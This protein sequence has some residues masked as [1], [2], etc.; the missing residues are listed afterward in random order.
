MKISKALKE[1]WEWKEAVYEETKNMDK[2]EVVKYFHKSVGRLLDKMD[3][4]KIEVS[5][6]VYRLSKK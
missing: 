4:K 2:K 1:V 5:N 3:Y 6:G